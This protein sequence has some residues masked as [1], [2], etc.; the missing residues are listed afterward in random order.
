MPLPPN[1]QQVMTEIGPSLGIEEVVEYSQQ[2]LWTLTID[3]STVVFAEY[4]E[5]S[6]QLILSV[7]IAEILTERRTEVMDSLLRYNGS[8]EQTGGV[9]MSLDAEGRIVQQSAVVPATDLDSQ[10]LHTTLMNFLSIM[11]HWRERIQ[12]GGGA[13][14]KD[15]PSAEG[16]TSPPPQFAVRI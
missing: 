12:H 2:S 5:G 10:M 4:H 7:D 13:A 9:C 3:T 6:R 1:L 16:E 8:W 15:G 11:G 14:P